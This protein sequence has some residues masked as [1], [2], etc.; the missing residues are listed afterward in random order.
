MCRIQI[1][2]HGCNHTTSQR[3]YC[4]VYIASNSPPTC[5]RGETMMPEARLDGPCPACA[6]PSSRPRAARAGFLGAGATKTGGWHM[7]KT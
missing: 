2:R 7:A 3:Q 4:S 5:P 6:P 1:Y